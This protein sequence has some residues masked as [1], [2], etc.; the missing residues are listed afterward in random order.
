[1]SYRTVQSSFQM[2]PAKQTKK[3]DRAMSLGATIL[4][5]QLNHIRRY[6]IV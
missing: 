4:C 1:M 3:V 6:T 5:I 2:I